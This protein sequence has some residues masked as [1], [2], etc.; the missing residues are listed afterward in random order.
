MN[1]DEFAEVPVVQFVVSGLIVW[2]AILALTS[3]MF[4]FL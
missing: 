2:C 1:D 3:W 4:G